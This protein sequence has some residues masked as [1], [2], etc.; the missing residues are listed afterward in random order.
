MALH[1]D[2]AHSAARRDGGRKLN[3]WPAPGARRV[4]DRPRCVLPQP[5]PGRGPTPTLNVSTVSSPTS[6]T[7]WDLGRIEAAGTSTWMVYTE[8]Q[9]GIAAAKQSDDGRPSCSTQRGRPFV[10]TGEGGLL[11]L[12]V[13]PDFDAPNHFV[14]ACYATSATCASCASRAK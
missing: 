2:E 4:G 5:P 9:V 14:Y 6:T 13:D 1:R 10:A 11:G 3:G 12:A 7:P 8:R